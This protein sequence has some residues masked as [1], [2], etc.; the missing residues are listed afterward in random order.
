[1]HIVFVEQGYPRPSGNIGGAGTYVQIIARQLVKNGHDVSVVCGVLKGGISSRFKDGAID[2]HCIIRDSKVAYFLSKIKIF[3]PITKLINY[4]VKGG[5]TYTYLGQINRSKEIDLIEYSE[6]GDFWNALFKTYVYISHLHGAAYTFKINSGESV[7]TADRI[8]RKAEHFFIKKA[9]HVVSPCFKMI[10]L[11]EGEIGEKLKSKNIIPYPLDPSQAA[12]DF[13]ITNYV[14]N[15]KVIIFFA[16]RNDPVK[17]GELLITALRK[18][19]ESITSKINVHFYGYTPKQSYKDLP[20]LTVHPF[21][22]KEELFKAYKT[23]NICVI[24]SFFDNSPNTV[25]EA[26]AAGKIVVASDAG[27]IPEILGD[28]QTNGFLFKKGRV[29]DLASKLNIAI[30]KVIKNDHIEIANNA[31]TRI[32]NLS[33]PEKNYCKRLDLFRKLLETH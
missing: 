29:E 24:P 17:G 27:G 26:L 13:K 2:V 15:E 23:A 20:F 18:L 30:T 7:T 3:S 16:S 12:K 28:N 4:L 10:E 19:E 21:V 33:S 8:Q 6:G 14:E 11:V 22:P 31:R 32:L 9:N 1:M 25:Y 5:K